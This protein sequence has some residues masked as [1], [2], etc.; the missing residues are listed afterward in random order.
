M[1]MSDASSNVTAQTPI[2]RR[3]VDKHFN[4]NW[5]ITLYMGLSL[6]HI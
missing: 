4:D 3:Q 2:T 5:I 1:P 6:I